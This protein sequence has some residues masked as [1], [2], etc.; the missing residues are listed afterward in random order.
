MSI[1]AE[2]LYSEIDQTCTE[3]NRDGSCCTEFVIGVLRGKVVTVRVYTDEEF[4]E[5]NLLDDD[6][7]IHVVVKALEV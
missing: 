4:R 3:M 1:N 7:D 5:D 6:D 2:L